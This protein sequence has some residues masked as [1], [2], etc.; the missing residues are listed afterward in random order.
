[1]RNVFEQF[2]TEQRGRLALFL[3][4]FLGAGILL[5]FG[6]ITEPTLT[7]A[8][9]LTLLPVLA[10]ALLWRWPVWRIPMLWL[11]L[12]AAGQLLGCVAALRA[13][14]WPGLP[15]HAVQVSGRVA[16]VDPLPTGRRIILQTPSLDG[17]PPLKR[18]L[19]LRLR[20]TDPVQIS[21]GD[22]ISVR[23]LIQPPAPPDF[24]GGWDTQRDAYFSGLGGYGFAIGPAAVLHHAGPTALATLRAQLAARIMAALPVPE[25]AI[26]ATLLTG[27]GTAIP[28]PDRAAFAA[29]GLAHLLAVAG[30]HI[31]IV[32]GLVFC[33]TRLALA[34]WEYAALAWPTRKLAALAALLT[35][36][37]YL[38]ITGAHIPILR[39][40]G[41]AALVTLGIL[42]GRRALSLRGL[43]LAATALMIAAPDSVVGVSF[44][45]SFSAVLCLIAGYELAQP[46]L[47]RLAAGRLWQRPLL[48]LAG[49]V[50]SSL[51]AGTAS[52]PFAAYHFGRA[53][54][55][56]V[57]ANM[58]AVPITAFWIM[59]WGLAALALLPLG[60]EKLA[61][62][63]MGWGIAA[64][65]SIA[66]HVAAWP[67]ATL[68][69]AQSPPWGLALVAAGLALGGLLRG[70]ARLASLPLAAIGLSAP[71]LVRPPDILVGPDAK[72]I[73]LRLAPEHIAAALTQASA[74]EDQAPSRLWGS[75]TPPTGLPCAPDTCR[76]DLNGH[77][78][79]VARETD[80]T[81]CNAA[82]IL[83]AGWLHTTCPAT[84]IID[85]AFVQR[86][87]ATTIRLDPAGPVIV[88]DRTERG[89]RPWVIDTHPTLPMAPTE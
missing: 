89:T 77:T 59:P 14:D 44:Q 36:F 12:V 40:F 35:G 21:P 20:D 6:R 38:E 11:S 86:E 71:F 84:P 16:T 82:L 3:P 72:L 1:M 39:S 63:P 85:H 62:V 24:P 28:A 34:A 2:L 64:L 42:C 33:A 19:R 5:Y 9:L 13:E 73:A 69:V 49:L 61:L 26:A 76:I 45:M 80:Q 43:A 83:S 55:Y 74:Y 68:P 87:G 75:D 15:R 23:C 66:R 54:L 70:H 18:A 51:L 81:D 79:I 29:S 25:G 7:W 53:T 17:G 10:A 31:G 8:G 27:A 52:L 32:M 78:I 57:P 46:L 60:L 47:R 67:F 22:A 65:D 30:L 58:L 88:T 37:L 4:V 48:Y 50:L 41:M 56:Y